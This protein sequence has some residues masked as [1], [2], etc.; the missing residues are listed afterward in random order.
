MLHNSD[1]PSSC[2]IVLVTHSF[3]LRQLEQLLTSQWL[4]WVKRPIHS[5]IYSTNMFWMPAVCQ[6]LLLFFSYNREQRMLHPIS[7]D[8]LWKFPPSSMRLK[9]FWGF[10]WHRQ[11]QSCC[12]SQR[13]LSTWLFKSKRCKHLIKAWNECKLTL[14]T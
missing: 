10:C 1:F 7:Q 14:L 5:F 8:S 2:Q 4:W 11:R 12:N 6:A 13:P 3:L 9:G